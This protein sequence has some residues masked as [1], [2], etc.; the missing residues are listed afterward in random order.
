MPFFMQLVSDTDEPRRAFENNVVV[1]DAVANGLPLEK[2]RRLLLELYQIVWYFNPI[3]AA[4]ASRMTD[5]YQ[6]V[7]YYLYEHL[8]EEAGHEEWVVNDLETIGVAQETIRSHKPDVSTL[9]LIGYNHW[10][11]D[12]RNPCSVLGM[13]YCLEVIASVYG[14]PFA[15]A[16][17]DSLLLEASSGISFI[18]SHAKLDVQHMVA[19][20]STLD[21]LTDAAAQESILESARVNFHYMTK[22]FESI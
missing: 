14:G 17:Q 9:G 8:H 16:I 21:V 6:K 20:R 2:Y 1:L 10:A 13:M 12:R 22:M 18:S 5:K 15:S 3:C 11:A 4:A 19:L 7:R